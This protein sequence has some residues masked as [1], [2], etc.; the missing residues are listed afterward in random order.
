MLGIERK[1]GLTL[2]CLSPRMER[3]PTNP[4]SRSCFQIHPVPLLAHRGT[5]LIGVMDHHWHK[6]FWQI[7]IP[8]QGPRRA[9]F[10]MSCLISVNLFHSN[11]GLFG[12]LLVVPDPG[13]RLG[14]RGQSESLYGSII[15]KILLMPRL[16]YENG[17]GNPPDTKHHHLPP[18]HLCGLSLRN[19]ETKEASQ[20][21]P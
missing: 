15:A 7:L 20:R 12:L 21:I 11:Q 5:G 17:E 4:E 9:K 1:E 16:S 13:M 8:D 3:P 6:R 18:G 19:P 2:L 14:G 10:K